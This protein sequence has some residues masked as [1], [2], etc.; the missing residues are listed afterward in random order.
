MATT[1]T[2]PTLVKVI[3]VLYYIGAVFLLLFAILLFVGAGSV[4]ALLSEIP[5]LGSIGAG[6]FIVLG[7]LFLALAV[8][9]FF[10]A[11]GLWKGRNW[12]RIVAI[13]FAIL[14]V[15]MAI[16]GIAGGAIGSNLFG[17]IISGLI[18]YYLLFNKQA[19]E[20]FA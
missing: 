13:I 12:A 19:K 2:V 11:R 20:A 17:L 3:S 15:V 7:V 18:G 8:L 14:G 10:V 1:K 5:L 9:D 4:G 16:F 6:V